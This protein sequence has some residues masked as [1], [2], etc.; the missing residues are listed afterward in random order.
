MVSL[1]EMVRWAVVGKRPIIECDMDR[2][3]R[4]RTMIKPNQGTLTVI[5]CRWIRSCGTLFANIDISPPE[6]IS[7]G[8]RLSG[9]ETS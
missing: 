9:I 2:K 6:R 7:L 5:F 8:L 1:V 4:L 3:Y